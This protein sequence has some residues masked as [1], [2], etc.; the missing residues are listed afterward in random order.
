MENIIRTIARSTEILLIL[1]LFVAAGFARDATTIPPGNMS[2]HG[3]ADV[4]LCC[5]PASPKMVFIGRGG[6]IDGKVNPDLIVHEG[7]QVEVTLISVPP[8][9]TRPPRSRRITAGRR[10]VPPCG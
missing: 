9:L 5:G 2:V 8:G 3:R 6:S 4:S 7:D 10:A 1:A